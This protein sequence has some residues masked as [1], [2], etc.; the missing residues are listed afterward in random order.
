[1]E[2]AGRSDRLWAAI[3]DRLLLLPVPIA[4]TILLPGMRNTGSMMP[5]TILALILALLGVILFQYWLLT[6]AGQ[7]VGKR[8]MGIKIVRVK[9]LQNGGFVV[10]VLL[11]S[12]AMIL[13]NL[14]PVVGTV[15]GLGDPLLIFRDDRRCLHDHIAGTCVIKA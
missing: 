7:T 15:A 12:L 6:T 9:D 4:A 13:V 1:M 8:M 14:I 5:F 2:L 10:N 3:I 11:R